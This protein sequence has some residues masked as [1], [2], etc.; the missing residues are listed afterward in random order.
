MKSKNYRKSVD[1]ESVSEDHGDEYSLSS[2]TKI[3]MWQLKT[4]LSRMRA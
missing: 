4:E 3:R 1:S 2:V